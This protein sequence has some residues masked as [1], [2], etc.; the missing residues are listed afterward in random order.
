MITH[1]HFHAFAVRKL[2]G[3]LQFAPYGNYETRNQSTIKL[4]MLSNEVF[5][6]KNFDWVLV[7]TDDVPF[8]K[9]Y[10]GLRLLSYSAENENYENACP[11]FLFESWKQVQIDDYEDTIKQMGKLGNLNPKTNV[12]G[13]RGAE[14]HPNRRLLLN[15]NNRDN[16]DIEFIN[17]DR[18][19]P[20]RL[21]CTNYVSL[22]DHVN[23]WRYLIDVEGGGWS[24]RTKLFFFSKRVVFLQDR[25]FKEWFYANIK[26]WVHYVPVN[27]DLSNLEENLNILKKDEALEKHIQNNAFNFAIENLRRINAIKRWNELLNEV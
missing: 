19:N 15:Y 3:K 22:F 2:D 18:T 1:P 24:A 6:F 16:Y 5:N 4:I 7:N 25:P 9:E 8:G 20:D 23:N 14:T 11:D 27:R 13:W 21:T 10:E 26:P 12:L 17:W